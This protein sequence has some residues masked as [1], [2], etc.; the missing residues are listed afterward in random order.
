LAK[1]ISDVSLYELVRQIGYKALWY[2]RTLTKIGRYYPSS[3]A[4]HKCGF[5]NENLTL[6]D[7]EWM[8]P[9]CR[10]H[11]DRDYNAAMNIMYEGKRTVGTTGLAG[12]PD[13]SP[14]L[15]RQLVGSEAA[16]SLAQR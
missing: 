11:H 6:G 9:R 12:C 15:S 3:K 10:E 1:A 13:V 2:G 4:C 8:C 14:A 5:I 7:R 16:G